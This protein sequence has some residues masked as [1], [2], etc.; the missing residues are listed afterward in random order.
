MQRFSFSGFSKVGS[1]SL[2]GNDWIVSE[3]ERLILSVVNHQK[4]NK[5]ILCVGLLSLVSLMNYLVLSLIGE[6]AHFEI[7]LLYSDKIP[8]DSRVVNSS[9]LISLITGTIAEVSA[10][11]FV[12]VKWFFPQKN[13]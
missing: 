7:S 10:L 4:W 12:V 13:P 5:T 11:L 1:V 6:I 9:I 2:V 3:K 8:P